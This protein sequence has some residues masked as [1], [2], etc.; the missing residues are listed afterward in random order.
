MNRLSDERIREIQS[1]WYEL[2]YI[3]AVARAAGV[4]RDTAKRYRPRNVPRVRYGRLSRSDRERI[5]AAWQL[6][7]NVTQV[8]EKVGCSPNVARHLRPPK[9]QRPG[10]YGYGSWSEETRRRWDEVWENLSDC[11][12]RQ[13]ARLMDQNNRPE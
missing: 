10:F 4:H 3:S 2:R 1:L 5:V 13:L 11:H 8:S 9:N 6:C 7:R 12:K